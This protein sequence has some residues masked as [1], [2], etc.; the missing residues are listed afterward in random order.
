[1]AGVWAPEHSVEAH[2]NQSSAADGC[3]S[4]SVAF[5]ITMMVTGFV[6]NALAML[7][8][9]RS[10]RR[11]ESK[12]KKSFLLCIGWLALTDLV[13]QLLTSPV[14]ILVYLSQRRWE[15][16]D[17]SGRLCTFFGLTMTVFGLSSLLVASAMAVER[18]LAIRAP[19][20]YASHMKTRAT[21]AVLLGV[22]LSVLAFALLPVLGVGRY[23]VQWP[24]TWCFI[25][26]G[27]AGNE[28]D[29]AR[30]P[31]SVAFAS[32]FACLGLL[33]LVVTFAC[34]LATI[35]A[36]VSRCR[37]KA[38]AS[39]SSAQWGRITTE[40]AIQLMGI[41]CVLSVCWSPL[42][43]MMLKMIFNQMSVEQ[44]KTQMGKEKECNSFL[45]AVRLASLNQ[46][47]DPWVY[48]LL[49]KILLRKFCQIRDHTNYASSSTSLPC[50]GSSVLMWSDQLER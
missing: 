1:M 4:V 46:I 10:Y 11:R 31:G 29:S 39:Q 9:S 28:T 44:C 20:W 25:S 26:T 45:I 32:A 13:G 12:R 34:N 41:M 2:S 47:L 27:P 38:A 37:A 15:Q 43:I 19:H 22:W 5:P 16:L 14:V 7:L 33:A 24:G 21:R 17:P 30:E 18:A 48:L 6:G 49:R 8:V 40:T 36:L 23:S 3:G 50:P 42:L 35:K